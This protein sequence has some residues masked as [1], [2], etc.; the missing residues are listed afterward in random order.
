M[1][2]DP[3]SLYAPASGL[4]SPVRAL[5]VGLIGLGHVGLGTYRVLLRNQAAIA[6][7]A[8]RPI[9]ITQVAVRDRQRAAALLAPQV[10]LVEVEALLRD[11]DIDVVVEAVGGTTL[12][13]DWVLQAIAQG[14]SV[15]TANKA[16]LAQHGDELFA[17]AAARGVSVAFE[18]AVAVSIPIIKALRESLSANRIDWVAGII[19]GTSNFILSEMRDKGLGFDAVLQEAQRLGYAEADPSFD[20]D[21]IDAAHKLSLLSA[22]AFGTPL[23]FD[24]ITVQGI[25]DLQAQDVGLAE[26]L[27]YRIKL[28]GVAQRLGTDEASPVSLRVQPVLLPRRHPLASVEGAMNGILVHGD[29]SGQSLFCGA[30]AGGE[31][32]GAAVI[33][34]LVDLARQPVGPAAAL[35][36]PHQA[37]HAQALRALPVQP[38]AESSAACYVRWPVQDA[39]AGLALLSERLAA[40]GIPVRSLQPHQVPGQAPAW[41]LLS[42]AAPES[43]WRALQA[44]LGASPVSAGAWTRLRIETLGQATEVG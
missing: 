13:R 8:G 14:K 26:A 22:L 1:Y 15:V 11:P 18:G 3:D 16:L 33:A 44:D 30:G 9:V 2:Q 32:T 29:A 42:A 17:A 35:R 10:R 34:D 19:N 37:F 20:V 24:Q 39:Q 12:A 21:G 5:R 28:L 4:K 43:A 7:R 31:P 38:L 25:R 36:V 23:Q 6:A 41:V 27:G 40:Q